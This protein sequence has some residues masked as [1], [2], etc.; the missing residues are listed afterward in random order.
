MI[1]S[2]FKV[3]LGMDFGFLSQHYI[4]SG[5]N[6]CFLSWMRKVLRLSFYRWN[7]CCLFMQSIPIQRTKSDIKIINF[8]NNYIRFNR[9]IS[10]CVFV[11]LDYIF[12]IYFYTTY[13]FS[14]WTY[15]RVA[16]NHSQIPYYAVF[17]FILF[18]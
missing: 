6:M 12:Y 18:N 14:L 8:F 4:T 3:Q 2:K 13:S 9:N 11:S 7:T 1:L 10:L 15:T 17:R 16:N 5:I